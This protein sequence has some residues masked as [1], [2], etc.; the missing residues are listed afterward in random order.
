MP[1]KIVKKTLSIVSLFILLLP[2]VVGA[3]GNQPASD[4]DQLQMGQFDALENAVTGQGDQEPA[5]VDSIVAYII[6]MALSFLGFIFIILIIVSGFQWMTA[7]GNEETIK[8]SRKR[9]TNAVIGLAI[10]IAAFAI[11]EFVLG[12]II[13]ATLR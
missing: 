6:R 7:G 9:M 11:S 1:F 2:A 13:N 8:T 4:L 10:V 5:S 3:A 12:T